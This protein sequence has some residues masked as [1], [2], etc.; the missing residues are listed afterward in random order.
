MK[1]DGARTCI[2][3]HRFN[4]KMVNTVPLDYFIRIFVCF[5]LFKDVLR[6]MAMLAMLCTISCC[7]YVRY[8]REHDS[9]GKENLQTRPLRFN[10][11]KIFLDASFIQ[12][13]RVGLVT[14]KQGFPKLYP[15]L[16]NSQDRARFGTNTEACQHSEAYMVQDVGTY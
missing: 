15:T 16:A 2:V 12:G 13:Q 10:C 7:R 4:A 3:E 14:K 5:D 9:F 1:E 11:I 8:N 6:L